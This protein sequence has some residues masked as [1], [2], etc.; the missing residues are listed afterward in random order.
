MAGMA[1]TDDSPIYE[2]F[3]CP[4]CLQN[5]DSVYQLQS[6][7]ETAHGSEDKVV[8]SKLKGFFGK[9]K[10]LITSRSEEQFSDVSRNEQGE[11]SPK[12]LQLL[13][14]DPFTWDN[15]ELGICFFIITQLDTNRLV[16]G[17]SL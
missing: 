15:P 13:G 11:G 7:V 4:M 16:D 1:A 9:A 5:F 10:N 2:G 8:L 12:K 6:H 3:L 17:F 14:S